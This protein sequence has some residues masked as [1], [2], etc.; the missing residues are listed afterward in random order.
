[1]ST[2]RRRPRSSRVSTVSAES[3]IGE[4]PELEPYSERLGVRVGKPCPLTEDVY[5]LFFLANV[6]HWY[7]APIEHSSSDIDYLI[8]NILTLVAA[9]I[10]L[11]TAIFVKYYEK[12]APKDLKTIYEGQLVI[13]C[14]YI[15]S[16]LL[17]MAVLPKLNQG[18]QTLKYAL[19]HPWHF[20]SLELQVF[21]S[22]LQILIVL[23]FELVK[24][25]V[26]YRTWNI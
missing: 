17:Q 6:E 21:I 26:F 11:I 22:G 1:M 15:G 16:I 9:H 8:N 10:V 18:M 25:Y 2:S 14:R 13:I 12:G 23:Y 5:T 3:E 7:G 20:K 19:N 24:I 4:E